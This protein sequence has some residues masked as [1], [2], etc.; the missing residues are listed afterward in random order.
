GCGLLKGNISTQVGELYPESDGEARTRAFA[1]FSMG[2]NV[3][4]VAGPLATGWLQETQGFHWGFGCAGVLMLLALLT[5]ALGLRHI[6]ADRPREDRT[7]VAPA[8]GARDWRVIGALAVAAGLSIFQSIAYYQ[9]SNIA[10][11]WID[12]NVDLNLLGFRVPTPWFNSIDPLA[13]I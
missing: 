7:V 8:L 10:L 5:Y 1:I 3:G 11:V 4:A 13:S 2:I 6:P 12:E 9:N